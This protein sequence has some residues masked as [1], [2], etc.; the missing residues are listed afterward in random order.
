MRLG[1]VVETAKQVKVQGTVDMAPSPF[2]GRPHVDENHPALIQVTCLQ[3]V[4]RHC[5]L[6][7][8]GG[9]LGLQARHQAEEQDRK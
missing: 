3:H 9:L 8:H 6:Y 4:Y 1:Q 5:A 7:F 2:A